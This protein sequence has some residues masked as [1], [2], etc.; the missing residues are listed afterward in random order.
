M[1]SVAEI[2]AVLPKLTTEDLQRIERALHQQYR[3]RHSGIVYD[4][5]YGVV[6][7]ADMMAAANEAFLTYDK[8]EQDGTGQTR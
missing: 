1:S 4:D 8:E 5:S 6:T 7:E 2:E 3:E